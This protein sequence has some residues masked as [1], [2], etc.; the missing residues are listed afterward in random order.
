VAEAGNTALV[1]DVAGLLR[2]P[3]PAPAKLS[4]ADLEALWDELS[5]TDGAQAYR[6]IQR[7]AAAPEG[8]PFL[9]RRRLQPPEPDERHLA[10]LVDDLD[11]D[12]FAV[13]ERA[14]Q[15]L[16]GLGLKAEAALR[17]ALEGQA[18]V[19]VRRRIENLLEKLKAGGLH[20]PSP[21]LISLR[22]LEALELSGSPT[23]Q[24]VIADLANGPPEA[25]LTREAKA[26]LGRLTQRPTPAP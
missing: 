12:E 14:S 17:R 23:A 10:R 11:A 18:S 21:E 3:W 19:E 15:E 5:G 25:R 4:A 22:V 20:L 24:E 7:L 9:R 2:E 6:A 16:A 1:C 13:R 8:A 26:S